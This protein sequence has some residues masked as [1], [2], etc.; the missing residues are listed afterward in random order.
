M[1]ASQDPP[2]EE[3]REPK[4]RKTQTPPTSPNKKK[5]TDDVNIIA[6]N[7]R[8][9]NNVKS[10]GVYFRASLTAMMTLSVI[11]LRYN[12]DQRADVFMTIATLACCKAME[13]F[14]EMIHLTM[15]DLIK[16]QRP[17]IFDMTSGS[18]I[19]VVAIL[20]GCITIHDMDIVQ[21][22]LS[23]TTVSRFSVPWDGRHEFAQILCNFYHHLYE[24]HLR[25]G[26][27]LKELRY[28]AITSVPAARQPPSI[29]FVTKLGNLI[30]LPTSLFQ[31]FRMYAE[32]KPII[33]SCVVPPEVYTLLFDVLKTSPEQWLS[34]KLRGFIVFQY[35]I[36]LY[37]HMKYMMRTEE[38]STKAMPS[39]QDHIR[40]LKSMSAEAWCPVLRH[41][42]PPTLVSGIPL[43][44]EGPINIP[45]RNRMSF[46]VL[47]THSIRTM[48]MLTEFPDDLSSILS[49]PVYGRITNDRFHALRV[50]SSETQR[51]CD[52]DAVI[53]PYK[54]RELYSTK[55]MP[56]ALFDALNGDFVHRTH[57]VGLVITRHMFGVDDEQD[58][59]YAK[60]LIADAT[61]QN[62]NGLVLPTF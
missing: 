57:K 47:A 34:S 22:Y 53:H 54:L 20:Q 52:H 28:H 30:S 1:E 31:T 23:S 27:G 7:D 59:E 50:V 11:H 33:G 62:P 10:N 39:I 8:V 60:E 6:F 21:R 41:H 26:Q 49:F 18:I 9:T 13:M 37:F 48:G 19:M 36:V 43:E 5:Q 12:P 29:Q 46:I 4:R 3:L 32:T 15:D 45:T 40:E 16:G 61:I 24:F 55:P 58:I 2:S 38:Q 14:R 56:M 35:L 44:S 42:F 51:D 25:E 17:R